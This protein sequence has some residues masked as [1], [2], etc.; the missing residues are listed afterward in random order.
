MSSS[1]HGG[2]DKGATSVLR[3]VGGRVDID[4][5]L[6]Q[7]S[8]MRDQYTLSS[9]ADSLGSVRASYGSRG[10]FETGTS[11]WDTDRSHVLS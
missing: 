5:S 10:T 2:G 9:W 4:R 11:Y 3:N 6:H 1:F 7:A 8:Q